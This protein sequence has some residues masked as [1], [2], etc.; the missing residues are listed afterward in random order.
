MTL[1]YECGRDNDKM[2]QQATYLGQELS[3]VIQKLFSGE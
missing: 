3:T 1:I 2:N